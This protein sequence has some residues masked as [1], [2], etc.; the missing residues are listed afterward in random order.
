MS[1][2]KTTSKRQSIMTSEMRE[3]CILKIMESTGWPRGLAEEELKKLL[4]LMNIRVE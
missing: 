2:L 3:D 1:M 4:E